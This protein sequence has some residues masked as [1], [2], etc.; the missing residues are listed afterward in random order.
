MIIPSLLFSFLLFPQ[1]PAPQGV[2]SDAQNL[3]YGSVIAWTW[4]DSSGTP[5]YKVSLDKGDTW[6]RTRETSYN[7]MLRYSEFDPVVDGVLPVPDELTAPENNELWIVQYEAKGIEP[8]RD[9]IRAM[10]GVAHRFLA[11]HANIWRMDSETASKVSKLPFVRWVGAFH[12]AYKLEDELLVAFLKGELTTRRYHIIVGEWGEVDKDSLTQALSAMDAE[13]ISAIPQG[14][15]VDA[16]LTPGQL[17]AVVARNEV[18]GID[19][20]GDPETDMNIVRQKMG[21]DYIEGIGGWDGTGVRAEVM[22]GN[23]ATG[24]WITHSTIWH[25]A[26]SGSTSHGTST[27]SINFSNG[28]GNSNHR[29]LAPDAQGIFADYGSY[30][31][32]YTHTAELVD[33]ND[34]YRAVYQSNS[35]GDSRTRSYTSKSQEMDDIIYI[36]DIVITQSQS[37]AGNQDSRPQA[38]AKNVVAVGGIYHYGNT[39][40]NDDDWSYGGS[41][42]PAEDGRIK[43]DLSAYYDQVETAASSSFGG[44]SA[45]S[46]IVAGHFALLHEMWHDGVFG[47]AVGSDVF[48][49]RPHST[50]ARALM[51]NSA[52]MWPSN[53]ADISRMRQGWGR[54]DLQHM[55]DNALNTQWV[56]EGVVL[57]DMESYT[58]QV[59][60]PPGQGEFRATMIYMDRAGTTS[61]SL[62]RIND[63]SLQVTSPSGTVYWGNNGLSNANVSSSGGSSNTKD[64]VERVIVA[65]PTSGTWTVTVHADDINQDTHPENGT[66][67]PDADFALAITP[68]LS[69]GGNDTINL[70]GPTIAW[71]STTLTWTWSGVPPGS[72]YYFAYSPSNAGAVYQGHDFDLGF[73]PTVLDTGTASN[74][75]TGG[76]TA[77]V[78]AGTSGRTV[79]FEAVATI[80]GNWY[81]SNMLTLSIL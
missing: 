37:N 56:D 63:M 20:M 75:G 6:G 21:A 8:F 47:N 27:Y 72:T 76:F 30:G 57:K 39:N 69:I 59:D 49:S 7:I 25:G 24:S 52:W 68:A 28:T 36:N 65:N 10:G 34:Q 70:V 53:Q 54:P 22:D 50:T 35:W 31:N 46:P 38:W 79:H 18:V 4:L 15:I 3:E 13:V 29:G 58:T 80:N 17:L 23:L 45:A 1:Q 9:E 5:H 48:D 19:R 32:R 64:S 78:P 40:D 67:P 42:G 74:N 33:P 51:I 55:Y 43:P 77:Q 2:P 60:V 16:R 71:P 11:N 62:H 73:P 44:T 14:W 81:D 66:S 12:P 61:S 41:T 26:H